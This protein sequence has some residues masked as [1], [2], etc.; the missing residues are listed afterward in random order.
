[1]SDIASLAVDK[2][3]L[4]LG[5]CVERMREIPDEFVDMILCDLPYG[6][7]ACAWDSIIPF[8]PLWEQYRR[9]IK[10]NGA[11]VLTASQPFTSTLVT[12][13]LKWFKYEWIW[14][15]DRQSGFMH[16]KNK[17]LKSHENVLVFSPGTT[18][19]AG[20]SSNRMTYN[21]QMTRGEPY[22]R[23]RKPHSGRFN[24]APSKANLKETETINTGTRYPL[25]VQKFNGRSDGGY[26]PTQKP[27][28]LFGYLILTY[29]NPGET[30]LENCFGSGT[31]GVACANTGRRFIGIE[32][33]TDYFEAGRRRIAAAIATLSQPAQQGGLFDAQAAD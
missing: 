29:T 6:T 5:D 7:T 11:I 19:H 4:M 3:W 23:L 25:S 10:G 26:H 28:E 27:V 33:A 13:N 9:V 20:Q 8:E 17:P 18:V 21:P 24:H 2:P 32:K 16:A 14:Q 12:S 22:H 30:V 1:M 15:K 31:T